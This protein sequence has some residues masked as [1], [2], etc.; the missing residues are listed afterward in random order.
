MGAYDYVG[1]ALAGGTPQFA[2]DPTQFVLTPQTAATDPRIGV[3]PVQGSGPAQVVPSLGQQ[4]GGGMTTLGG[5]MNKPGVAQALAMAGQLGTGMGGRG[6][7][8]NDVS[9]LATKLAAGKGVGVGTQPTLPGLVPNQP[10]QP[11]QQPAAQAPAQVAQ[12][13]PAGEPTTTVTRKYDINGDGVV[14]QDEIKYVNSGGALTRVG[15]EVAGNPMV[16]AGNQAGTPVASQ[17]PARDLGRNDNLMMLS[18]LTNPDF[19]LE[20]AKQEPIAMNAN[21]AMMEAQNK[22]ALLPYEQAH[23]LALSQDLNAKLYGMFSYSPQAQGLVEQAKAIGTARGQQIVVD[24]FAAS[25]AGL[26]PVPKEMIGVV[27]GVVPGMTM[28]QLA[29]QAGSLK[30]LHD[31]VKLYTDTIIA[32]G[33]D[34]ARLGAAKIGANALDKATV[35]QQVIALTNLNATFDRE[36][37]LI[38]GQIK[39]LTDP[40]NTMLLS[41]KEKAAS[42]V[43]VENL[44]SQLAEISDSKSRTVKALTTIGGVDVSATPA[45]V[46]KTKPQ[47]FNDKAA[48]QAYAAQLGPGNFT[49]TELNGVFTVTPKAAP[50]RR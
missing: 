50:R 48:A 24:D 1:S 4:I 27:P 31:Y 7:L 25:P 8:A 38:A 2:F 16:S 10:P 12:T 36:Q 9:A 46:D 13:A 21:A 28:G 14:T 45:S 3:G 49:A 18:G 6:L 29:K 40:A 42:L 41:P 44:R 19:A 43:T 20:V 47:T 5:I 15:A 30:E 23:K 26:M 11:A 17:A 22:R 34:A 33:H 37:R 35:G 32:R 39:E